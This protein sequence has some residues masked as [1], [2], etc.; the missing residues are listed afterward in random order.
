M[1][2]R[3]GERCLNVL[4]PERGQGRH[5]RRRRL[6]GEAGI[7]GVERAVGREVG[8]KV[9]A[10]L[11]GGAVVGLPVLL[12][13]IKYSA[14]WGSRGPCGGDEGQRVLVEAEPFSRCQGGAGRHR[15][16]GGVSGLRP[17]RPLEA[18]GFAAR[19]ARRA[20]S[21]MFPA[22]TDWLVPVHWSLLAIDH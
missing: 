18:N 5:V 21:E 3:D 20:L 15:R 1:S 22:G 4:N 6:R 8:G 13:L 11:G 16:G 9:A 14:S 19:T 17:L 12:L 7:D 10:F 2:E